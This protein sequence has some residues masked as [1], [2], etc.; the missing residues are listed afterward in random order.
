MN[1]QFELLAPGGDVDSIKA[2]II[3]GAD[4]VYCGLDRFNAR[5][6]AANLSFDELMGVSKLAHENDCKVFLTLNIIILEYEI[7]ALLQLLN[8]LV[9]SKID[10]LI[11][12]DIGLFHLL[13]KYFKSLVVHA[14][15]QTTTHN[16][17]QILFL[18]KLGVSR[19][20]LCREL[21][22]NEIK[23]LTAFAHENSVST[24][25][26]IHGSYCIGFSGLCYL[27]SAYGG[28]SGNRGR[29]TQPCRDQFLTTST[30]SDFPLNLK[31]NSAFS[32]LQLL[33]EAGVDALKIEG[34]RKGPTYV[35]TVVDCWRKQLQRY[36]QDVPLLDDDPTLYKVFN[37]GFSNG[38]LHGKIGKAMFS[39]TPRDN[40]IRQAEQEAEQALHREKLAMVDR[41][42]EKIKDLSIAKRPLTINVSGS[43]NTLLKVSISTPKEDFVLFSEALLRRA[44]QMNIIPNEI[45]RRFRSLNSGECFIED[46]VFDDLQSDV[47]I[48]HKELTN[49]KN[50]IASILNGSKELIK[51]VALPAL[52]EQQSSPEKAQL[53]VLISSKKDLGLCQINLADFYFKLPEGLKEERS[54]FVRLFKEN[55]QLIPWFP[56]VL[57]GDDYSAALTFLEEVRPRLVVTNN[58]GIA[59]EAYENGIE[60]IAGPYLNITNSFSLLAMSEEFNCS[61]SF[62]SNELN[63]KQIKKIRRPDNFKLF[64]SIYHPL[65]LMSSRQCF[66]QQTVG[67]EKTV[68]DEQCMP[69]CCKFTSI[70]SSKGHS[71]LI[72]KQKGGYPSINSDGL[73]LNTDIVSDLPGFFDGFFIDLSDFGPA[74][75][76][77]QDKAHIVSLFE[78]LL[79]GKADAERQIKRVIVRS[80]NSQYKKGL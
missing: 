62:V 47:S 9:N 61:G 45:K 38:Y 31:D 51:P 6:R 5:S 52:N 53:S 67:C 35:Q 50:R 41:V 34:R 72:D 23:S 79:N 70:V 40:T 55:E 68:V 27:S 28:N 11:V 63:Q 14:S 69:E 20:N 71:L 19:V 10:A 44:K 21:S 15:T 30:G 39:D 37:R 57:I 4:A 49:I 78:D 12:Q 54:E 24:E 46:I 17:G 76:N 36:E 7:P 33:I 60:W 74:K 8:R 65:L 16:E 22:F 2:A 66:F 13:S 75:N 80:T 43:E 1:R 3:A 58:T 29:C 32:D 42:Q 56:A 48:A 26:F 59:Y 18:K 25:V 73:F 77:I 64:Y